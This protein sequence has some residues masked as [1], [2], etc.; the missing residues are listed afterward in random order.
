[1]T[2]YWIDLGLAGYAQ[3]HDLQQRLVRLRRS[4]LHRDVLL[5]LEH[6]PV[7]TLGRR[8]NREN[9]CVSE[10]FLEQHAIDL[11]HIERGGDITFHGP[12]QI[13]VYPI[14][15]L[16]ERRLAVK[17]YVWKLEEIMLQTSAHFSISAC[18]DQ[19]NHGIWVG[20][21]KM[22]SIGIAIRHSVTYH[23]LALNV[24]TDLQPFSWINPCGLQ[25][26]AMTSMAKESGTPINMSRVRDAL[27]TQFSEQ[28]NLDL[29]TVDTD[30]LA[31]LLR[32]SEQ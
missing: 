31:P 26:T 18:R 13:V 24:N 7:Y 22:G 1:M 12:G 19:R 30:T 20:D 29:E 6:T 28:L 15:N 2:G 5:I 14:I 8:G 21:S 3:V 16:K 23:G 32:S 10:E 25:N 9:L 27:Q 11:V 4:E 17:E